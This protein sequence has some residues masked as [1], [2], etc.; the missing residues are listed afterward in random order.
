MRQGRE[1]TRKHALNNALKKSTS[2]QPSEWPPQQRQREQIT[3][4]H[5]QLLNTSHFVLSP[6][7]W[8]LKCVTFK[9][10]VHNNKLGD[11]QKN[12]GFSDPMN[13]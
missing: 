9:R 8:A 11:I 13:Y 10:D 6:A 2:V 7:L 4:C 3:P 5:Y 1:R 12:K